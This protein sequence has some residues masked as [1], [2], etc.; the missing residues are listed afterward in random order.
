MVSIF[1][2]GISQNTK[3][4]NSVS[5]LIS[6]HIP[7]SSTTAMQNPMGKFWDI[8]GIHCSSC[9]IPTLLHQIPKLVC[10]GMFWVLLI[11]MNSS[12]ALASSI[13]ISANKSHPKWCLCTSYFIYHSYAPIPVSLQ[14]TPLEAHQRPQLVTQD[15]LKIGVCLTTSML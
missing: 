8:H 9:T 14:A 11:T 12:L 15:S 6:G 2:I 1:E 13:K 7:V 10:S 4:D 5:F 3:C